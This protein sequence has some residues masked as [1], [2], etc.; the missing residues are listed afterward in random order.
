MK[1]LSP[2]AAHSE[3]AWSSAPVLSV[4]GTPIAGT[5]FGLELV[6]LGRV[7]YRAL[8]PALAAALAAA[9]VLYQG[10]A[11]PDFAAAV[12]AAINAAIKRKTD[13]QQD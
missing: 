12:T 6:V 1:S 8:V 13:D 4:F 3:R 11:S 5:V 9:N 10:S 7:E 2:L